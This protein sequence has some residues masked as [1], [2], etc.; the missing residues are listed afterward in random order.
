MVQLTLLDLEEEKWGTPGLD[1]RVYMR[2]QTDAALLVT[3]H[4]VTG[5]SSDPP[6]IS[7][8]PKF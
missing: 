5:G 7:R 3:A 2:G 1:G 4:K 8:P 6:L